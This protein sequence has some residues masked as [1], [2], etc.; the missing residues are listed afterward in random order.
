MS[1]PSER[2]LT[3]LLGSS[4]FNLTLRRGSDPPRSAFIA[5]LAQ[6]DKV[7]E[8]LQILLDRCEG[9]APNDQ[10]G[11]SREPIIGD[12]KYCV[13]RFTSQPQSIRNAIETFIIAILNSKA[14][15]SLKASRVRM[16]TYLR[17]RFRLTGAP[18]QRKVRF[19]EPKPQQGGQSYTGQPTPSDTGIRR[20]MENGGSAFVARNVPRG[21]LYPS[22]VP[23]EAEEENDLFP[24]ES[25][26]KEPDRQVMEP[27][28]LYQYINQTKHQ[29]Y[30]TFDEF[31][32]DLPSWDEFFESERWTIESVNHL[33]KQAG[34]QATLS[35]DMFLPPPLPGAS[36]GE[37]I[38][39]L[40]K[41]YPKV[42]NLNRLRGDF[43]SAALNP[44]YHVNAW[45][46]NRAAQSVSLPGAAAALGD[47]LSA[48]NILSDGLDMVLNA[49]SQDKGNGASTQAGRAA[50]SSTATA[51]SGVGAGF[52]G[53]TGAPGGGSSV[54]NPP[55]QT[56]AQ[57]QQQ[58]QPTSTPQQSQQ[59]FSSPQTTARATRT[60]QQQ[61]QQTSTP[62]PRE[63]DPPVP[64]LRQQSSYLNQAPRN[65]DF[66]KYVDL[67]VTRALER[68][69]NLR[70]SNKFNAQ[71]KKVKAGLKNWFNDDLTDRGREAVLQEAKETYE[72]VKNLHTELSDQG[73]YSKLS[74]LWY[75][76]TGDLIPLASP[77]FEQLAFRELKGHTHSP[78]PPSVRYVITLA[79]NYV[80]EAIRAGGDP[81]EYR[82]IADDLV[83]KFRGKYATVSKAEKKTLDDMYKLKISK[84]VNLDEEPHDPLGDLERV[85]NFADSKFKKV[86]RQYGY[87]EDTL[88]FGTGGSESGSGPAAL[89]FG[90]GG[91]ESGSGPAAG[92]AGERNAWSGKKS[93]TGSTGSAGQRTR[94]FNTNSAGRRLLNDQLE[95]MNLDTLAADSNMPPAMVLASMV[96]SYLQRN[97][98]KVQEFIE[99]SGKTAVDYIYDLIE[100]GW[101]KTFTELHPEVKAQIENP[102]LIDQYESVVKHPNSVESRRLGQM[103]EDV[104][105]QE[106]GADTNWRDILESKGINPDNKAF[107]PDEPIVSKG[108]PHRGDNQHIM[109]PTEAPEE[110]KEEK[111]GKNAQRHP[112]V[113]PTEP[114]PDTVT[115]FARRFWDR[116]AAKPTPSEP[117]H[118]PNPLPDIP[119]TPT[120]TPSQGTVAIPTDT[121]KS[122]S[123]STPGIPIIPLTNTTVPEDDQPQDDNVTDGRKDYVGNYRVPTSTR[124][125]S[126][127]IDVEEVK[128]PML[129]PSFQEGGADIVG[130]IN[131]DQ[132]LE[133]INRM[134]WQSFNNYSWESN[135]ER[136]NPLFAMEIIEDS[137]RF[138]SPLDGEEDLPM[139]A[140][141]ARQE[142]AFMD[143]APPYHVN[144]QVD[145]SAEFEDFMMDVIPEPH[146]I[147]SS[148]GTD[149]LFHNVYL[150][151]WTEIPESSP[152]KEF[153]A[154]D[155]TQIPDSLIK[156]PNEISDYNWPRY[157]RENRFIM[158]T[159][160]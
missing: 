26:I 90:T 157:N 110:L 159:L 120:D 126:E 99:K 70:R 95:I 115:G 62:G 135:Q 149:A 59:P 65:A 5:E 83:N 81:A 57:Q 17:R 154:T 146:S 108:R 100:N 125:F 88:D 58:Q 92:S 117:P 40:K 19:S 119:Q 7:A 3:A 129:R 156:H 50:V 127:F 54:G 153:T 111:D 10:N 103:Y 55:P 16:D 84:I 75:K 93:T 36:S 37:V 9:K 44:S 20:Q 67:L 73:A 28:S 15:K 53:G 47:P 79:D 68:P 142:E 139:K 2:Q 72:N 49:Q 91:S 24:S 112:I 89:D 60:Q 107:N 105:D 128:E 131:N 1:I 97:P 42:M 77:E 4:I 124:K 138:T 137:R 130:A 116:I 12:V 31:I 66:D 48:P 86:P 13:D 121:P 94:G 150:P 76:A 22:H 102:T 35:R 143:F 29:I 87:G 144:K 147:R 122:T 106:L 85:A 45:V 136:D 46:N 141:E 160:S 118:P 133:E 145:Q 43:T 69:G 158:S 33:W 51:Q 134:V 21:G 11:Y 23:M 34:F 80:D 151:S 8:T 25:N 64:P 30:E 18:G 123:T 27:A 38:E 140:Q 109:E 96:G 113:T 114:E 71:R 63:P 82:K 155:G 52:T 74:Q 32:R 101:V 78:L 41:L 104:V 98:E 56:R 148:R 61:Q 152:W 132:K 6:D 14:F 39:W